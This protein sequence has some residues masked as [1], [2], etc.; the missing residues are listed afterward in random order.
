[1]QCDAVCCSVL[2]CVAVRCRV[3]Q[4]DA[5]CVLQQPVAPPREQPQLL[6]PTPWTLNPKPKTLNPKRI[7]ICMTCLSHM[8]V[9]PHSHL[10][11]ASLIQAHLTHM[12][13]KCYSY[14]WH[15]SLTHVSDASLTFEWRLTHRDIPSSY[16]RCTLNL[17][18]YTLNALTYTK[19]RRVRIGQC[20][21]R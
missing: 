4:C 19:I 20:N 16:V 17:K 12:W 8:W 1:M 5:V 6:N 2:Q 7:V 13:K 15:A 9:M 11:D 10:S 18:H 14:V 3:L 21:N